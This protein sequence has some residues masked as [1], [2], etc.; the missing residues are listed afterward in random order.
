M[1]GGLCLDSHKI[2][3]AGRGIKERWPKQKL[4]IEV[5]KDRDVLGGEVVPSCFASKLED[6]I[7]RGKSRN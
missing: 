1:S 4:F 3:L 2:F 5:N 6:F 7:N